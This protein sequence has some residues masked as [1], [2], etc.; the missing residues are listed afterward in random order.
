GRDEVAELLLELAGLEQLLDDVGTADELAFDEQLRER[1]PVRVFLHPAADVG[2]RQDVDRRVLGDQGVE[3]VHDGCRE[4]ALRKAA[5]P[6]HEQD[7]G[8]RGDE[9]VDLL[10]NLRVEGH[11]GSWWLLARSRSAR[12]PRSARSLPRP[13]MRSIT[14]HPRFSAT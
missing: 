5:R 11:K 7:D 13:G 2:V 3:D 4:S 12:S 6:L 8:I 14:G 9:L 1:R 10:A